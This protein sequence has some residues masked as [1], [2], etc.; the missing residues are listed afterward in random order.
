VEVVGEGEGEGEDEAEE[1]GGG[2][3]GAGTKTLIPKCHLRPSSFAG[4]KKNYA[5][6]KKTLPTLIKEKEPL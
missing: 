1:G 6:S 5:G 2:G 3:A 4:I